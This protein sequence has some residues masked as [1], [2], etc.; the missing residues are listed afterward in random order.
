[1]CMFLDTS[2]STSARVLQVRTSMA[3][4]LRRLHNGLVNRLSGQ[5][6]DFSP[7]AVQY[8]NTTT[9]ARLLLEYYCTR[10]LQLYCSYLLL[11]LEYS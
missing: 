4:L 3:T 6:L 1:M 2:P 11:V 5:K 9:P 10:A 8:Y 7:T